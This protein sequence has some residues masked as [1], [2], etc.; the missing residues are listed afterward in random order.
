MALM[1]SLAIH[2][3]NAMANRTAPVS[4]ENETGSHGLIT[5]EQSPG[6]YQKIWYQFDIGLLN[7]D[8]TVFSSVSHFL[9]IPIPTMPAPFLPKASQ[10]SRFSRFRIYSDTHNFPNIQ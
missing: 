8:L 4:E 1:I 3:K 6:F 9:R 5:I 2:P 10:I 7:P